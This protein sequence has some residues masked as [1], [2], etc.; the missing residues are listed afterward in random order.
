MTET[1]EVINFKDAV[2]IHYLYSDPDD[3]DK[4]FLFKVVIEDLLHLSCEGMQIISPQLIADWDHQKFMTVDIRVKFK[5]GTIVSIK[6]Q[7]SAFIMPHYKH[8][9]TYTAKM[10]AKQME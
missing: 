4:L 9:A 2:F 1:K 10:L 8:F 3:E 5:D 7:Q 6:M